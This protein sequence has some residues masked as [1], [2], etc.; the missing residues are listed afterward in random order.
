MRALMCSA[1]GTGLLKSLRVNG[2]LATKICEAYES[3]AHKLLCLSCSPL[4]SQHLLAQSL[5]KSKAFRP[6]AV[7]RVDVDVA[8]VTDIPVTATPDARPVFGDAPPYPRIVIAGHDQ[9]GKAELLCSQRSRYLKAIGIGR[10]HEQGRTDAA[11]TDKAGADGGQA[12]KAVGD[13][14]YWLPLRVDGLAHPCRP[15]GKTRPIP[16]GLFDP[17]GIGERV[18]EPGLPMAWATVAQTRDDEDGL[19]GFADQDR[20]AALSF[21]L[22]SF[23]GLPKRADTPRMMPTAKSVENDFFP[24]SK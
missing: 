21:M 16:V 3:P 15:F 5:E 13:N 14:P 10:G 18:F 1:P 17:P 20:I 7:T 23:P 9:A 2:N 6:W 8:G 11:R 12:T 4:E 24:I 22:F 19:H